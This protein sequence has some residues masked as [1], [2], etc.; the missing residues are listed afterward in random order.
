ME[1]NDIILLPHNKINF[2]HWDK[3]ITN[4]YNC[5]IYALSSY[6][7][8]IT[9][10]KWNALI[11]GN[12]DYIMPLPI[13]RKLFLKVALQ[14]KFAQQ[15]GIFSPHKITSG[16]I[17]GFVN[18]IPK[19]IKYLELN[20]NIHNDLSILECNKHKQIK[21][22]TNYEL[23]LIQPYNELY[24]QF[25]ENTKRNIKKSQKNNIKVIN[26]DANTFYNFFKSHFTKQVKKSLTKQDFDTLKKLTHFT[27]ISIDFNSIFKAAVSQDNKILAVAYF[28]SKNNRIYYLD[29]ISS[30][31]GREQSAMFAIFNNMIESYSGKPAIFDFEGS[32]IS[33]I[34]RFYKGFGATS[35][36]YYT[37]II[38]NIGYIANMKR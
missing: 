36:K 15:L 6:L 16:I 9:K 20:F 21:T 26:I 5:R 19:S 35:T 22:N 30:L 34:A 29:G 24:S 3:V 32:N 8:I 14:P 4:S 27:N 28:L 38:N 1:A 10:G 17:E 25:S 11:L 18:A 13:K 7:N 2:K 23:D 12:Y 31:Q 37:L 33:N